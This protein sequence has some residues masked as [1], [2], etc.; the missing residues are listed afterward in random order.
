M[1]EFILVEKWPRYDQKALDFHGAG[2]HVDPIEACRLCA[3][4]F[5]SVVSCINSLKIGVDE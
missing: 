2:L 5:C 4:A 3:L 1:T